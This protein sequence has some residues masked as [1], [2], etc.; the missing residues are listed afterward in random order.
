MATLDASKLAAA[1]LALVQ[2]VRNLSV[3]VRLTGACIEYTGPT[4]ESSAATRAVGR[5]WLAPPGARV[6]GW[7]YQMRVLVT[8]QEGYLGSVLNVH[9]PVSFGVLVND[10]G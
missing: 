10:L 2:H 9:A 3:P 4:I 8:G 5:R 7:S 6:I 1:L